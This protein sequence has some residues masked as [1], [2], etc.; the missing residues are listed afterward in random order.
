MM[1]SECMPLIRVRSEGMARSLESRDLTSV[2]DYDAASSSGCRRSEG[3]WYLHRQG[4]DVRALPEDLSIQQHCYEALR[5]HKVQLYSFLNSA[6]DGSEWPPLLFGRLTSQ[7]RT[8]QYQGRSGRFREVHNADERAW[9][10]GRGPEA[11]LCCIY[12]CVYR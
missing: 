11:Q 7:E 6:L 9:R 10:S 3:L 8:T 5:T 2:S 12:F 1:T 4:C